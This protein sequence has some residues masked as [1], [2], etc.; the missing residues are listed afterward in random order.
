MKKICFIIPFILF[1]NLTLHAQDIITMT[2]GKKTAC[3]I[4]N[5]D[6]TRIFVK[7]KWDHREITTFLNKSEVKSVYDGEDIPP[8]FN[9]RNAV[10]KINFILPSLELEARLDNYTNLILG[11]MPGIAFIK[12]NN[13]PTE[14]IL[15]NQFKA[16]FRYYYNINERNQKGKNTF[17]YSGNF[18]SAYAVMGMKSS[19]SNSFVS[20]GPTWGFQRTWWNVLNFSFELGIGAV[21]SNSLTYFMPQG[22]LRF[23]LPL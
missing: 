5:I 21:F 19:V 7:M 4:L 23:G 13:D 16:S 15:V 11:Y 1:L 20:I 9:D 18:I 10:F 14:V 12:I 17:K 8:P 6:S 3:R 2:N 22:D